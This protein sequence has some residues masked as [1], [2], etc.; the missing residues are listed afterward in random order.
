MNFNIYFFY[1]SYGVLKQYKS[2]VLVSVRYAWLT[3]KGRA[4]KGYLHVLHLNKFTQF[5]HFHLQNKQKVQ[6]ELKYGNPLLN[7]KTVLTAQTHEF[8]NDG[9]DLCSEGHL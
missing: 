1:C 9:S 8:S 2:C 4:G 7:V 5:H 3:V 6:F